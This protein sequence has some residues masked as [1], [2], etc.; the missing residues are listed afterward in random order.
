[1]KN[2]NPNFRMD[3]GNSVNMIRIPQ[4]VHDIFYQ[5]SPLPKTS[6]NTGFAEKRGSKKTCFLLYFMECPTTFM[7]FQLKLSSSQ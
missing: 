3:M 1:M 2:W 5:F 4:K 7:K 6:Q